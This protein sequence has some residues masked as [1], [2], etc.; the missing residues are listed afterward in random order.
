MKKLILAAI[1]ASAL[2]LA[3][4][5]DSDTQNSSDSASNAATSAADDIGSAASKAADSAG[6]AASNTRDAGFVAAL[7]VANLKFGSDDDMVDEAKDVCE[8]LQGGKSATEAADSVKDK[9]NDDAGK[10][11]NFVRTAVPL[12]CA[13]ETGK[14]IG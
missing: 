2:V 6:N 5:S 7:G 4:C 9:Y 3:G 10:A 14:L 1:A 11:L 13:T 8:D 12:Y